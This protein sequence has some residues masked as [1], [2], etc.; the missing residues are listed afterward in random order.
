MPDIF[1]RLCADPEEWN[2]SGAKDQIEDVEQVS[3]LHTK[4]LKGAM[5]SAM[6]Y[7]SADMLMVNDL[8]PIA[9]EHFIAYARGHFLDHGFHNAL[10]IM[11]ENTP[12][13]DKE[14]RLPIME[15]MLRHRS[16]PGYE[17]S[18]IPEETIEVLRQ[19]SAGWWDLAVQELVSFRKTSEEEIKTVQTNLEAE[20]ESLRGKCER[21]VYEI[22]YDTRRLLQ[23]Q[24]NGLID[25]VNSGDN[26]RCKHN[27]KIYCHAVDPRDTAWKGSQWGMRMAYECTTC[28]GYGYN[29]NCEDPPS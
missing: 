10:R 22:E 29:Y 13:D 15:T 9:R 3:S 7:Q 11:F 17:W 4:L 23:A 25:T 16:R 24:A 20:Y 1:Q 2:L 18:P 8:K 5:V 28:Q 26:L 27:L 14:L 12:E 19:H 21:Q 6:V